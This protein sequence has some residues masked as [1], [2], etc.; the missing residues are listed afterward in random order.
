MTEQE[1]RAKVVGI[2]QS[3]IGCKESDGSHKK[4]IDIYNSHKPLAHGYKVKYTDAWCSTF[5][6]AVAIVAKLTDIIPTECSC[7]RHIQL[8][9]VLGSWQEN[10]AYVPFPGDYYSI[11]QIAVNKRHLQLTQE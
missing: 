1:L 10:D 6:S 8:F 2:A 3:Y 9:K 7:E 5:A 4:I 11:A